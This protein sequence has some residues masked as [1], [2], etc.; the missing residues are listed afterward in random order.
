MKNS[1]QEIIDELTQIIEAAKTNN[2]P[3]G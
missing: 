2:D 3:A 1:I